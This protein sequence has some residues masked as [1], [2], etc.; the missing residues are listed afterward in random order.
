[1]LNVVVVTDLE[2][3]PGG[4]KA[5]V[6]TTLERLSFDEKAV[7]TRVPS[8]ATGISADIFSNCNVVI[9][10]PS[11]HLKLSAKLFEKINER[12]YIFNVGAGKEQLSEFVKETA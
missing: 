3:L 5:L 6:Q 11:D 12:V 7:I 2:R 4:V 8:S 1:M 10:R 9:I